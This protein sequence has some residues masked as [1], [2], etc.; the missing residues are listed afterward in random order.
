[1]SRPAESCRLPLHLN[2]Y[3]VCGENIRKGV[4]EG[5]DKGKMYDGPVNKPRLVFRSIENYV[6]A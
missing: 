2:T 4:A 6:N 5:V 3:S 1:M